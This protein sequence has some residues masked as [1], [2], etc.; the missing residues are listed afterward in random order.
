MENGCVHVK[1]IS[2]GDIM[3]PT[4]NVCELSKR[5]ESIIYK[6]YCNGTVSEKK[7]CPEW[8]PT[9]AAENYYDKLIKLNKK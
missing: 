3:N 6:I 2:V 7:Q 1:T 9:L 8:G 5:G 4:R